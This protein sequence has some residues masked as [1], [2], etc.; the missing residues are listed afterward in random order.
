M[1][2]NIN[3]IGEYIYNHKL[4]YFLSFVLLWYLIWLL[5]KIIKNKLN[6]K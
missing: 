1:E 4:L 3:Q 5:V 6:K 2:F